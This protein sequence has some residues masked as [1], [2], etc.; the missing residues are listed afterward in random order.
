[1]KIGKLLKT[2]LT[3]QKFQQCL[4]QLTPTGNENEGYETVI[5]V[6][7]AH[8]R[9]CHAVIQGALSYLVKPHRV[10]TKLSET[11]F[12]KIFFGIQTT[13]QQQALSHF[14][15]DLEQ[16]IH[17]YFVSLATHWTPSFTSLGETSY[18]RKAESEYPPDFV[19]LE[20][21]SKTPLC[22]E[23][24]LNY[25]LHHLSLHS[26]L[27]VATSNDLTQKPETLYLIGSRAEIENALSIL[28]QKASPKPRQ[29]VSDL[30][31]SLKKQ[32]SRAI[33]RL[34]WFN[35]AY[36]QSSLRSKGLP[37][38]LL[39]AIHDAFFEPLKSGEQATP[40]RG[41]V[42]IFTCNPL[43][44]NFEKAYSLY[45]ERKELKVGLVSQDE[46]KKEDIERL[47][48]GYALFTLMP[49]GEELDAF[50]LIPSQL[51][52]CNFFYIRSPT[53]EEFTA[54]QIALEK[55]E[56]HFSG[57]L[58]H[59]DEKYARI[60]QQRKIERL[61]VRAESQEAL[62]SPTHKM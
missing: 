3:N 33:A 22:D 20:H 38:E 16:A 9:A 6:N 25:Y 28:V 13:E 42:V 30:A 4:Q 51:L 19:I 55:K 47:D 58:I 37:L 24:F 11:V 17:A 26:A 31:L 18:K 49:P 48:W 60:I 41:Q 23:I 1:M 59:D 7:P 56:A 34:S 45:P 35:E 39:Q 54:I 50:P 46:W 14:I 36:T 21:G 53:L 5:S 29:V 52:Q 2:I 61:R 32:C 44:L 8:S 10:F 43:R 15:D 40:Y 12:I 62:T 27:Q 57:A